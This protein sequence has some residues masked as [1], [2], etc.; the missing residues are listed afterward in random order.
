[1]FAPRAVGGAKGKAKEPALPS[2][3]ALAPAMPAR[4]PVSAAA[5]P[6]TPVAAPVVDEAATAR[7]HADILFA[8]EACLS[9]WGLWLRPALL[10]RL[11]Q[12]EEGCKSGALAPAAD[13]S[14]V[15]LSNLLAHDW[16]ASFETTQPELATAIGVSE[17][18][19]VRAG[20]PRPALTA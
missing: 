17:L 13:R 19:E 14:D 16:L 18:L 20:R 7:R 10:E 12:H 11:V 3:A 1:M 8:V 4:E 9:D 15:H 2:V 5:E 6:E